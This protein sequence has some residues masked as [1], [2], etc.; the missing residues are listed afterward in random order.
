MSKTRD[1]KRNFLTNIKNNKLSSA[2]IQ[3]YFKYTLD[4]EERDY[5]VKKLPNKYFNLFYNNP[6]PY[7]INDLCKYNYVFIENTNIIAEL[8]WYIDC[9]N[10]F[11]KEI[12]DFLKLRTEFE[13]ELLI[14]NQSDSRN[15]LKNIINSVGNSYY[16][17]QSELYINEMLNEGEKNIEIIKNVLNRDY[18]KLAVLLDFSRLRIS[19][20][21]SPWQFDSLLQQHKKRYDSNSVINEYI[22][23]KID[24]LNLNKKIT[25]NT[26]I[27]YYDSDFSMV[28]RYIGLKLMLP[29]ILFESEIS[30][31][32]KEIIYDKIY[33]LSKIINDDYWNKLLLLDKSE[34]YNLEIKKNTENYNLIQDYYFNSNYKHVIELCSNILKTNPSFTDVY[35]FFVKS[36]I[37][38]NQQ[39]A[40]YLS[41]ET[42][43]YSILRLIEIILR[44]EKTY[45]SDRDKLIKKYY[46]I[47]HFNFSTYILEFIYNEIQV[48]VGQPIRIA[49][50]LN[51]SGYKYNIYHVIPDIKKLTQLINSIGFAE[52]FEEI[53]KY[54]VEDLE[55][56]NLD[57]NSKYSFFKI[58]IIVSCLIKN[59]NYK[60][61]L[62][63]LLDFQSNKI[64]NFTETE[65]MNTW[66]N[67]TIINCYLTL[68]QHEKACDLIV[69]SFFDNGIAYDHY[70]N[71]DLIE[72]LSRME[73][74]KFY[75]YLSIP[76][77]FEIYNQPQDLI[78]DSLANFLIQYDVYLP[79]EMID[80]SEK[81]PKKNFIYFLEKVC[82]T[83][84]IED[85]PFLNSIGQL[86]EER[87]KLLNHLKEINSD[88]IEQYNEEILNITRESSI[89]KGLMQIHES[90]IYI[91]TL[92]VS[93]VLESQ[94]PEI[95]DR[96][97][98]M[99]DISYQGVSS[100]KINQKINT[101][102]ISKVTYY[103]KDGYDMGQINF[104]IEKGLS[105]EDKMVIV[106]FI[107]FNYFQIIFEK[108]KKEFVY[109][110]DYG[111]KSFLSMRI[112]H[113]TFLNVLRSI[114]D[115]HNLISFKGQN[116]DN[117]LEIGFWNDSLGVSKESEFKLQELLKAF[118]KEVDN[119]I[120]KG[121]A[122]INIV[123]SNEDSDRAIF[124]FEFDENELLSL[125]H[126]RIGK[127][128]EYSKFVE[129]IY[130]VLYERLD[131]CL[132]KL[133]DEISQKLSLSFVKLLEKLQIDIE[134]INLSRTNQ[135]QII[136]RIVNCK[137]EIQVICEQVS[138]WFKISKNQYIEEFP[139]D[140]IL[141]TSL[142]YID[143][144]NRNIIKKA[145]VNI[146]NI[147]EEKFKGKYFE[148]F[149]DM[150]IN[151]FDNIISKNKD[152]EEKLEIN[153]D[154]KSL[155]SYLE[156]KISNNLSEAINIEELNNKV[157]EIKLKIDNYKK[158]NLIS[159][160]EEGSGY[161]KICKCISSDLERNNYS[162]KVNNTS[163]IFE[164]EIGFNLKN[165]IS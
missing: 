148:S 19:N 113:G 158:G 120:D 151:V 154:I 161:L 37:K 68:N 43:L 144:I 83:E 5:I 74:D 146:S 129:E 41:E 102:E 96:Y 136:P 138:N 15:K 16:T 59:K 156:I 35:I 119:E 6:F 89:R 58:K 46:S 139:I 86:E 21:I 20:K 36:L 107:R 60:A 165:L 73:E 103:L 24:P 121:L 125:F 48:N 110:D 100:L 142:N 52:S 87:I 30:A 90:R 62:K 49:A 26:F 45:I 2:N 159:S 57:I 112:R 63:V 53:K 25:N 65:Y 118:S 27:A 97:I 117:Y 93:K 115:K 82:I 123:T 12:N 47:C 92:G 109:N 88:K 64:E 130:Q 79:S 3:A 44:K 23:Y 162:I 106:P 164:V 140:L 33:N 13:N 70:F 84:N 4:Q 131:K 160:F 81:F 150:F 55:I 28:D 153:I 1:K 29:K 66:F 38:Q 147:C 135:N 56:D 54:L 71:N 42:E 104:D 80:L 152:L 75:K 7:E 98:D 145:S 32:D 76:I 78:Y 116:S 157:A 61:A 91:D 14:G 132:S 94:I 9:I 10:N 77:L 149:G 22:D 143:T 95:F 108:I 8:S 163:K 128:D 85:S 114:F 17:I 67:R 155:D 124:N 105:I 34:K 18:S 111:F 127:L 126:T 99:T 31:I 134:K 72:K 50:Y 133:R 69:N 122:L 137:T 141:D 101:Q 39:I 11:S 51:N 40:N